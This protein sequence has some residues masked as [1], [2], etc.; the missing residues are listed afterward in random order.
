[1]KKIIL[2]VAIAM[3]GFTSVNAQDIPAVIGADD[4]TQGW[5]KGDWLL[6]GSINYS[7]STQDEDKDNSF[8][9]MP[10][11]ANFVTP[12]LAIGAEFGYMSST[13]EF[14]GS[15]N[16]TQEQNTF[17]AGPFAYYYC[18]P[19]KRFSPYTGLHV[20]YESTDFKSSDFKESGFSAELSIGGNYFLNDD[21]SMNL[22]VGALRYSSVKADFDD[23]EARNDFGIGVDLKNVWF[24]VNRRF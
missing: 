20:N 21:W 19:E 17:M 14:G 5:Q 4:F 7:S 6:S 15:S 9:I 22:S 16:S 1:M 13:M 10:R 3:F 18:M 24:G 2:F 11:V 23:A 12:N 8:A